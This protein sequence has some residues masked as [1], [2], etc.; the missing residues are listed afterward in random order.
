M[1]TDR[2]GRVFIVILN[3]NGWRDTIECLESVFRLEGDGVVSI[4]CDNGSGDSSLERITE[5]AGGG[6]DA[7]KTPFLDGDPVPKPIS[8]RRYSRDEAERGPVDVAPLVLIDNGANLGF[9]GGCNVGIRYA[10]RRPECGYVWLLNND[11]VVDPAAL[12]EMLALCRANPRLGICGSQ[13]RLYGS[14]GRIQVFGGLLN[15][16]LCT[17]HG[18]YCGADAS[19]VTAPPGRIDYVP[20]A[21]VLVTRPF[22]EKIGLMCEEYFLYFEEIDWAERGRGTFDVG[23]CVKSLVFHRGAASIGSPREPGERGVRSEY[24]LLRSRL[25]FARKFFR[26]RLPVVYCGLVISILKRVMRGQWL[27]ARVALC[28]LLGVRPAMAGLPEKLIGE[29]T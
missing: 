24:F 3:W 21:S 27:R 14:P 6:L 16:W 23:V 12:R 15:R 18:L 22:L 11:T 28:A 25:L 9:A 4:V 8:Y 2:E 26:R 7:R 13:I 19:R 20:G 29:G 10:L 5:W 17:T 1:R